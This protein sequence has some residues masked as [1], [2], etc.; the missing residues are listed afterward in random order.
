ML[1]ETQGAEGGKLLD[2]AQL[3]E[4]ALLS[5]PPAALSFSR[6]RGRFRPPCDRP[7]GIGGDPDCA[8]APPG[9]PN[10]HHRHH[11][12]RGMIMRTARARRAER[13]ARRSRRPCSQTPFARA[14]P[15][16][17]HGI[18]LVLHQEDDRGS[19]LVRTAAPTRRR[20][21]AGEST[22][23][24]VSSRRVVHTPAAGVHRMGSRKGL[25]N[26]VQPDCV[27]STG[28]NGE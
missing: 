12:G 26:G 20:S 23:S 19:R 24:P 21:T 22:R 15:D 2:E 11:P 6:S 1:P 28:V 27:P 25:A 3:G 13:R 7:S 14:R 4:V 9:T 10:I 16:P 8:S 17:P 5:K 18:G